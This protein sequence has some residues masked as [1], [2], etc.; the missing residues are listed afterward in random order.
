MMVVYKKYKYVIHY[1]ST[2]CCLLARAS[3]KTFKA[4]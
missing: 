1:S 3:L 4:V 2:T